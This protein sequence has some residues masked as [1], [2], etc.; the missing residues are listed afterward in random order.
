MTIVQATQKFERWLIQQ[1][2]VVRAQLAE[3]HQRMAESPLIFLRGT[4]YRWSQTWH[5]VCPELAVAPQVMAVGDLHIDSFGTWRDVAGRLVWG[6]DDFD[7]AFY[8]PYTQDLLRLAASARLALSEESLA[9]GWKDACDA[10]LEGYRD[11]LNSGGSA[12]VLEEK[13]HWLRT[14]ALSRLD[15]PRPFWKKLLANPPA[16]KPVPPG[17]L[18]AIKQ[19]LPEPNLNYRINTRSAGVGSLGHRRFVALIDWCGG[20]L[21]LEAKALVPSAFYWA[22]RRHKPP[23]PIYYQQLLDGAVRARD[24]FVRLIGPWILRQ[25]SPDSSPV[26]LASLPSRRP[27]DRLL[28]AM[29]WEAANVHL[30][31]RRSIKAVQSDLE[32]RPADWLRSAARQ[33]SKLI[34]KDWKD[35]RK[36]QS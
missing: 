20:K 29:G 19:L 5:D 30:T 1:T 3:K 31:S 27:E 4:I 22:E 33:I 6:A 8:L 28:H 14:I 21:A 34:V 11:G 23:L 9:L 18:H 16:R 13:H 36:H 2:S 7:E 24:P 15:D 25:L 35:W 10:I 26:E 32:R 17:A 12:F